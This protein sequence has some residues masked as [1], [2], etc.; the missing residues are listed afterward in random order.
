MAKFYDDNVR[1]G[2]LKVLSKQ[3]SEE[4]ENIIRKIAKSN[5]GKL[6]KIKLNNGGKNDRN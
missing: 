5:R 4:V 1:T 2:K 3:D 6:P